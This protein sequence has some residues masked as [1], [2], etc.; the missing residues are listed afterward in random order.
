MPTLRPSPVAFQHYA[1]YGRVTPIPYTIVR[2]MSNWVMPQSV[3]KSGTVPNTSKAVWLDG[4]EVRW[5]GWWLILRRPARVA[6]CQARVCA[7]AREQAVAACTQEQV[8]RDAA[9]GMG[10]TCDARL[11]ASAPTHVLL[12]AA[13]GGLCDRCAQR[14]AGSKEHEM[15]SHVRV[16]LRTLSCGPRKRTPTPGISPCGATTLPRPHIN[17]RQ[18]MPTQSSPALPLCW[19]RPQ[20]RRALPVHA[21]TQRR[22]SMKSGADRGQSAEG[23]A[24]ARAGCAA[25]PG[26][27]PGAAPAREI[28]G[29]MPGALH[30]E[31]MK[32]P[33]R[34]I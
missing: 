30:S 13:T 17:P 7:C 18:A 1:G 23:V 19:R 12:L 9:P 6:G 31:A 25:A 14:A 27:S 33:P 2:G 22:D 20:R 16:L 28:R 34:A 32:P 4:V 5:A 21:V 24:P 10:F 11:T 29:P 26:G 8:A 3:V 15:G